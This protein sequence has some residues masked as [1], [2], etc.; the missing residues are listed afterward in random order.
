MA[1]K[2]EIFTS[3]LKYVG[4]FQFRKFYEFC[5]DW[6]TEETEL[7]V[8]EE[9]YEEKLDGEMK[10]LEI[11]W[12]GRKKI[13]DY[14]KFEV[15]VTFRIIGLTNVEVM[16]NNQKTKANKGEVKIKCA[17][18]L[19]RDYEGKFETGSFKKF[20]RSIYEKWVIPSRIEQYEDKLA[21]KCN[22]FLA[23]AKAFLDLEG[24]K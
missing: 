10:H 21:G 5:Y 6:L 23:Q 12:V 16:Q 20:L 4:I 22:E 15:K 11:K 9:K 24:R 13:T 19:I 18:T 17:G 8:A 1:E 3:A 14:F 7:E 2:E